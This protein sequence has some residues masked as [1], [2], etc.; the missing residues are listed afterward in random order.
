MLRMKNQIREGEEGVGDGADSDF[1]QWDK[2]R[3]HHGLTAS[4]ASGS[5]SKESACRC[6]RHKR[7]RFD[8]GSGRS[9]REG[10]G[11]SVQYSCLEN[12]IDRGNWQATVMGLQ[13]AGYD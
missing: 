6:R 1:K 2:E 11:N 7:C 13:R 5:R 8:P 10:N 4:G 9:S 12:S 3:A